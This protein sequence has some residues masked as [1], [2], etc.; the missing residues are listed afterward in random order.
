MPVWFGY[1]V[2]KLAL[3]KFRPA[4][5]KRATG[6][7][8][9]LVR[10]PAGRRDDNDHLAGMTS[11]NGGHRRGQVTVRRNQY[12]HVERVIRRVLEHLHGDIHIGHLFLGSIPSA[13]AASTPNWFRKVM[14]IVKRRV[15]K[16]HQRLQIDCLPALFVRFTWTCDHPGRKILDGG[17]QLVWLEQISSKSLDVEPIV[18]SPTSGPHPK[19]QIEP[20]DVYDDPSHQPPSP[21]HQQDGGFDSVAQFRYA[22][23][24]SPASDSIAGPTPPSGGVSLF[25]DALS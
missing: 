20:I 16:Q 25:N 15:R 9:Q 7:S 18:A 4:Q 13:A 6:K 12:R 19:I 22:A 10:V 24:Y 11:A 2:P 14:A 21:L 23:G 8:P 1:A 5:L 3:R 17:Q